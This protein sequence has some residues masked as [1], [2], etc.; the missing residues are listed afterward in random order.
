MKIEDISGLLRDSELTFLVLSIPVFPAN[1]T[2]MY[3]YSL[4]PSDRNQET[5]IK[6]LIQEA[7]TR[8]RNAAV[9]MHFLKHW[10]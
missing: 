8:T 10:L 1:K 2:F 4:N 7:D 5:K 3:G 9:N 6:L